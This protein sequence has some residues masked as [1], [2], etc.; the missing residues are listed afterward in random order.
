MEI[1]GNVVYYLLAQEFDDVVFGPRGST[2]LS[3]VVDYPILYD[4]PSDM[5][6]HTVLVPDHE[7]PHPCKAM[8]GSLCVCTGSELAAWFEKEG[9]PYVH[10]RDSVTFQHL[11][12]YMQ[13][14]SVAHERLD[15]QLHAHVDTFAGFQPMLDA[16]T[17]TFGCSCTL[18]DKSYRRVCYSVGSDLLDSASTDLH[19]AG[20]FEEEAAD[21]FMASHNYMR[22]R[23]SR[24]VFSPPGSAGLFMK[25][26]FSGNELVG[27]LIMPHAGSVASARFV[28]FLLGYFA[29]FVERMY[30]RTG[31]FGNDASSSNQIRSALTMALSG[32][33]IDAVATDALLIND[34]HAKQ[35]TYALL[36]LERSFSQEG[37]EGVRYLAQRVEQSWKKSYAVVV[38]GSLYVMAYMG[39]DEGERFHALRTDI[40]ELLRD[41]MAKAGVSRLFSS[42]ASLAVAR[43]QARAALDQGSADNPTFWYYHFEDYALAW[44]LAR[45]CGDIPAEYVCHPAVSTLSCYD[46]DNGTELLR[47]L[48]A[49]M[50]CR[51]NASAAAHELFVA[52]STLLNRLERIEELAHVDLDDIDERIYLGASLKLLG[53]G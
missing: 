32:K 40:P 15:A 19:G 44:L 3:F 5:S 23:A 14:D 30:V 37:D 41:V 21:L 22:L 42:T 50:R 31:S 2:S 6:G 7:R 17:S 11:Y 33:E 25:N 46:K 16:L 4:A 53:Q 43:F 26:V 52:R 1:P 45:G 28:R 27:T 8:E 48:D 34:G 9:M 10:V 18:V 39:V 12:N 13:I 29:P 36:L 51:Y 24:K 20:M 49:F 47:T 38:D 35:S